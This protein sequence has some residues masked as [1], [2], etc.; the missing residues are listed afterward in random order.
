MFSFLYIFPDKAV[1]F[2]V[3][4]LLS[5]SHR[6][7]QTGE[8][9]GR[10]V[11]TK[12]IVNSI[13]LASV[14]HFFMLPIVIWHKNTTELGVVLHETFV[15]AYFLSAMTQIYSSNLFLNSLVF[16]AFIKIE[17]CFFWFKLRFSVVIH[18]SRWFAAFVVGLAAILKWIVVKEVA[19]TIYL[20]QK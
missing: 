8:D 15:A 10:L 19:Q 3:L 14:S 17:C 12:N 7:L 20:W 16:I 4:R 2:V 11:S 13:T 1:L 6:S 18:R 5:L 9:S